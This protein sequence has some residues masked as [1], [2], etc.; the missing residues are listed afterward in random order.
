M[1]PTGV[2]TLL[3]ADIE[4][5]T[6][7]WETRP[8]A[9]T[10][11][12]A[13]YDALLTTTLA[14]H[15]GVRP[16]EQG[17]GDS[18]VAAFAMAT[19][20][21]ECALDLQRA[22]SGGDWPF[23]VRM[24]LHT[25]EVQQRD[26]GNYIGT[27][28]NRCARLRAIAHGGQTV[29]S[30][31]VRDLVAE[32]LPDRASLDDAG[33][34][35]LRDLSSPEHVYVLRH[36]D[37]ASNDSPLRS[38]D[39][40]ANNLP[41]ELTSFVGRRQEIA[42]VGELLGANRMVT[43]L[44][45]G[46]CGKT[47]LSLQVAARA[48]DEFPGGI[49]FV[50]FA[51]IDDPELVGQA[52]ATAVGVRE[53]PGR[54]MVDTLAS[55][56]LHNDT[57]LVFDNCE[58]LV[59]ATASLASSLLSRC[60]GLRILASSREALGVPGELT[61]TVP[62]LPVAGDAVELFVERATK[63]RPDFALNADNTEAVTLI[64]EQLDGIPLA[65]ELAAARLRMLSAAQVCDGLADRFRLLTTG[66]RTLLPRQ[67]TLRASVDWSFDLLSPDERTALCRLSVFAGGF[68]LEAAVDVVAGG[69]IAAADVLDLVGSLVDKSLVLAEEHAGAVRYRMLETL[70]QYGAERL[71]EAGDGPAVAASH[72]EHY[73][74]LLRRA[75]AGEE[76]P[77][78]S[79][80]T[81]RVRAELDNI[82]AA[83]QSALS[84]ADHDA[85]IELTCATGNTW[86]L[87]GG[88]TEHRR[89]L[90]E[91]IA[92]APD[93]SPL[94]AS[95]L[96]QLGITDMFLGDMAASKQRLGDSIP[97]YRSLGDEIGALWAHAE[98]AWAVA[99]EDGLVEA[100]P[101]YDD[102]IAAARA[103]GAAAGGALFSMEYGLAF[104]CALTGHLG[105]AR[106]RFAALVPEAA[107]GEHF[108]RW[109]RC[110]HAF[111]LMMLG[112]V[113]AALEFVDDVVTDS[114]VAGDVVALMPAMWAF[115]CGRIHAGDLAAARAA[116]EESLALTRDHNAYGMPIA[117][118]GMCLLALTEDDADAAVRIVAEGVDI[119]GRVAP[120]M[121]ALL[122]TLRADALLAAGDLAAAGAA[123]ANL[124][125]LDAECDTP[126]FRASGLLAAGRLARLRD[127]PAASEG[128]FH[129]ALGIF[130]PM[131]HKAGVIEALEALAGIASAAEQGDEAV[132]LVAAAD[133]LRTECGCRLRT[134]TQ[135]RAYDETMATV[136]T[137]LEPD[138]FDA[139]WNQG[140]A[141]AWEEACDYAARGRGTRRRP[142]AGW[143]AL[144]PMEAKVVALVADGLTNPQVGERLFI[145]KH[146]VDSHLRHVFAKLGVSSRAELAAQ[147]ARRDGADA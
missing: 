77:E 136:R 93:D 79:V 55:S 44:G 75:A 63:A 114:R 101:L 33:V 4:G 57:L 118:H 117:F 32:R 83:L 97:L 116:M 81:A 50:E 24:A 124:L 31:S 47:R 80:W 53:Q 51:P 139:A 74:S 89:W 69:P 14:R 123:V 95:A 82:R 46:G 26:E 102:G 129:D 7:L 71:A 122:E 146:T 2:V 127:D 17:E 131:G 15:D 27:T 135:H 40:V 35:R 108:G 120:A 140:A 86:T 144:S 28:I 49:W 99:F 5:S 52:V 130:R 133:A 37:V 12:I 87:V 19:D 70:R 10:A 73:R 39:A 72:R 13:R 126:A 45:T 68:D 111:T 30:R 84:D 3:L 142:S 59:A 128:H 64:C 65:I 48:V 21:V 91:A 78:Q 23:R 147:A 60:R 29:L 88:S 56:L 34:H 92:R 98:W 22:L 106:N 16:V 58:H 76:G 125:Q 9:M 41:V 67:Q 61:F 54:P 104:A 113:H 103:A 100:R 85:L 38:L 94:R 43:L 115:G 66:A 112:E 119:A 36:P 11:A 90:D 121:L 138:A 6:V 109:A 1:L 42:T 18:F 96:Y 25:G 110:G 143:A 134:P 145:S 62:S 20:A 8:E 105:E 141:M 132:R 137:R 107:P